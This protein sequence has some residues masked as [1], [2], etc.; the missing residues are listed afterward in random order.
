MWQLWLN[1][2]SCVSAARAP[3]PR[4]VIRLHDGVYATACPIRLLTVLDK[5]MRKY[6]PIVVEWKLKPLDAL[7]TLAGLFAAHRTPEHLRSHN[8]LE[9][10]SQVVQE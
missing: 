3:R 5:Y 8:G 10:T 9:F 6:R 7:D 1:D 2:G 4:V